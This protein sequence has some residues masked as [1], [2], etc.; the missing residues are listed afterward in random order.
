MAP[1]S[2]DCGAKS[3]D[4]GV[5]SPLLVTLKTAKESLFF[6]SRSILFLV[7]VQVFCL[8]TWPADPV[9]A[10]FGAA[11]PQRTLCTQ[12]RAM[13][14]MHVCGGH[15]CVLQLLHARLPPSSSTKSPLGKKVDLRHQSGRIQSS[16]LLYGKI[17][18]NSK[19]RYPLCAFI[20]K[21]MFTNKLGL[22]VIFC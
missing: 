10:F 5:K 12:S 6:P 21:I 15:C 7:C 1:K 2:P 20:D 22:C 17:F 19:L 13:P 11:R 9:Q 8:A 4:G 16:Y 14:S 3:P 18:S